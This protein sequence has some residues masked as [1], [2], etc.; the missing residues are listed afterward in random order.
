VKRLPYIF[1]TLI[2]LLSAFLFF[3]TF[4]HQLTSGPMTVWDAIYAR[5]GGRLWWIHW[6]QGDEIEISTVA[7]WPTAECSLAQNHAPLLVGGNTPATATTSSWHWA[8]LRGQTANRY[9]RY[10][11]DGTS[12]HTDETNTKGRTF[13]YESGRMRYAS[14]T[15]PTRAVI[16]LLALVPL[17]WCA[18]TYARLRHR[19]RHRRRAVLGLCPTC[20]YDLRASP[21]RCPECGTRR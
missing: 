16:I 5:P 2:A 8:G 12:V 14:V 4:A 6:R 9:T 13:G 18:V 15:V 3:A 1:F 19:H 21:T 20:G 11:V 10:S 17:A 7:G